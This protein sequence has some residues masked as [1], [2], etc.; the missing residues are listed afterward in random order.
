MNLAPRAGEPAGEGL[1]PKPWRRLQP[2][3]DDHDA[4]HHRGHR[5]SRPVPSRHLTLLRV[6]TRAH[7]KLKALAVLPD[8]RHRGIGEH[9]LATALR[10]HE[11]AG[12][13]H[14]HGHIDADNIVLASWY[15][16]IGFTVLPPKGEL[17][18]MMGPAP[19]P[20]PLSYPN[21]ANS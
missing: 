10:L 13:I 9:L 21:Q 19:C 17:E 4:G 2:P 6:A 8:Y 3:H 7:V 18:L 5:C 16:R 11:E 20:P 14:A 1:L 12:G 15:Q